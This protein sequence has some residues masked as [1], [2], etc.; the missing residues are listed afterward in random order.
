MAISYVYKKL[1][2]EDR[3]IIAYNAHKQY[4][5]FSSSAE[6]NQL[7][8]FGKSY[9]TS[10]SISLYSSAS[11]AY[12]G[13][14][15]NVIKYNQVDRLFYKD[16]PKK[17]HQIKDFCDYNKQKRELHEQV[18]ILSIPVGLIGSEIKKT[19]FY[20]SSSAYELVDDSYG[21]LIISGTDV[22]KYP[23][24]I[25]ENILRLDPIKSFKKYDL[26]VHEGYANVYGR[27]IIGEY[28][29][30]HQEFFRKG[31]IIPGP[32][33]TYTSNNDR[34]PKYYY[35]KDEDDTYFFN[36]IDYYN[37]TFS[38]S[39][40]LAYDGAAFPT[41]GFNSAT[42]SYIKLDHDHKWNFKKDQ[43]FSIS[44]WIRPTATGSQA[45][46]L[47]TEKRYIIAKSTTY[48]KI[49]NAPGFAGAGTEVAINSSSLLVP[50]PITTTNFPFE[51][52]L[53]SQSL[54][55]QRSDGNEL[56]KVN[57]EITQSGQLV[58]AKT[59][60]ILCQYSSSK[61]QIWLN[62][63]KKGETT[64][65][66]T[67]STQNDANLYIGSKGIP[68]DD[69]KDDTGTLPYRTFNGH[70]NNIN[71]WSRAYDATTIANIS[72]SV[73]A[74]PIIGNLFYK[75]GFATITHPKYMSI[76]QGTNT[77]TQIHN[78]QFQGTHLMYEHE[79]Q[80][81]VSEHEFNHTLN[82]ST[83]K[84]TST[85]SSELEGFTSSSY[86]SPFVTTIGL[87]NDAY[88][89]LAVAK[90]GQPTRMSDETDT[91]FIVRFDE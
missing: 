23:N 74:S 49:T 64:S 38:K 1:N 56:H 33:S 22:D 66:F 34:L 29:Y 14:T 9:W 67:K 82:G 40:E 55:F 65:N 81:T 63:V 76:L 87:Y 71:I 86:F 11:A 20:L 50:S 51:I 90:L 57:C 58:T 30:I 27:E 21:N 45:D 15:K 83:L 31:S 42:S 72:E 4:N 10:E 19:S 36:E 80:C 2:P 26:G 60:H 79:Y 28:Q 84:D 43:E 69:M 17:I 78:I 8:L 41:I 54:Y 39:P 52:Y 89:M 68:T 53:Q 5:F 16:Y 61:M 3:A 12:G 70:L 37:V 85:N 91:T 47:N 77:T 6:S 35:P 25:H 73:N 62:G 32:P 75:N 46:I 59:S 24:N 7:K 44:F 48:D 88:E 13:D 18:N